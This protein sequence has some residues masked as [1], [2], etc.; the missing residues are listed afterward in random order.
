[1]ELPTYE[2][3]KEL[4]YSK[5]LK[6]RLKSSFELLD[7]YDDLSLY[8]EEDDFTE[9]YLHSMYDEEVLAVMSA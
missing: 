6:K 3:W 7:K 5:N 4:T 8:L 1:M 2:E 9:A